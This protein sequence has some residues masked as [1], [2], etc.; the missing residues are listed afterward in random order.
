M[1]FTFKR[2]KRRSIDMTPLIDIIFQLVIFFMLSTSFIDLEAIDV[3]VGDK[4]SKPSK[5]LTINNK[6]STMNIVLS[7]SS[8]ELNGQ[9]LEAEQL[10]K[11]LKSNLKKDRKAQIN[12]IATEGVNVQRL[13]NLVDM[14]RV[15][16][17]S[18]V[19]INHD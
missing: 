16:G 8:F 14:V 3:M 6:K 5:E 2:R 10:E 7:R 11:T 12:I 19:T 9:E 17:G 4:S 18:N 13:T 15:A 1:E